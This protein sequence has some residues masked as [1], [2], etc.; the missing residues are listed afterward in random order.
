MILLVQG[1]ILAAAPQN[2]RTAHPT[3]HPPIRQDG[4]REGGKER[5]ERPV[6]L[7]RPSCRKGRGGGE[8]GLR[9]V[10]L[11]FFRLKKT[12]CAVRSTSSLN[13]NVEEEESEGERALLFAASIRRD[14]IFQGGRGKIKE[15]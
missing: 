12:S 14:L 2:A 15:M 1:C 4:R 9:P 5:K 3:P 11:D 7:P 8:G 6:C 10:A 13:A